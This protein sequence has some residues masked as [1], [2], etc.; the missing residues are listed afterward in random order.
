M[1]GHGEL[2]QVRARRWL[3][4][5]VV[6]PKIPEQSSLVRL[7]CA[8]DD[9]QGQA[10]EV[11]WDYEPDRC[12]LEE[13]GWGDL[14]SQGFD[15]GSTGYTV[16][17]RDFKKIVAIFRLALPY[18]GVVVST[19]EPAEL[20]DELFF[21]GASQISAG[22]KTSPWGYIKGD[23]TEQF[24]TGDKRSLEEMIDKIAEIGLI[25][26]LCTACYREGRSGER[27]RHLTEDGAMKRFCR[28]NA[29]LSLKEYVEDCAVGDRKDI[30]LKI[31]ENEGARG[32]N[33]LFDKYM[34]IEKGKRDVHV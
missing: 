31:L 22:S 7:A 17:D 9:N 1:H 30:L 26:S 18:V 13:E 2:V 24:E 10:L 25:P 15:A 11:F 29:L 28:E 4:E 14:A 21:T 34:K 12:I 16:S 8:D 6:T 27:F 19:R 33:G 23:D 5:E 20:R 32:T 3:V